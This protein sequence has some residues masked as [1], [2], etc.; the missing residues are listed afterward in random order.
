[1]QKYALPPVGRNARLGLDMLPGASPVANRQKWGNTML[2]LHTWGTTNGRRPIIMLEEAGLP[3]KI[4]PVDIQNGGNKTPQ[5]LAISPFGKIPALVDTEGPG[6]QK[7][8]MFEST[9]ILMYLADKSGKFGGT[10]PSKR[11][12]VQKWLIF[13]VANVL[14]TFSIMRQHKELEATAVKLLDVLE[15]QLSRNDFLAGEYSIAD[16]TPVTRLVQ[17]AD[18]EW[19]KARPNVARW[20]AKVT[21]RPAVKKAL[22]M[23][24]A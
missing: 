8:T 7:I 20:L 24:I 18:H 2:E 23:A 13:N 9:A 11:A 1:M 3:Y 12:D 6:G 10:T 21:S 4:V 22:E 17:F 14:P 16:M 19:M 5:H 15:S